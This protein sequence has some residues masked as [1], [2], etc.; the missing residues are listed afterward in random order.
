MDGADTGELRGFAHPLR[1]RLLSLLTGT[2]MSAA[3]AARELGESQ[4]N[5]SYHMRRLRAAGL[6]ELAEE[7][8]IRGG[9]ARRYRHDPE[10]GMRQPGYTQQGHVATAAA[11]GRELRRRSAGRKPGAGRSSLTDAEL[12]VEPEV[13]EE[14]VAGVAALSTRLHAAARPPHSPGTIRTSTTVS[15]FE[16]DEP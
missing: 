3:E 5:V 15:L 14:I 12:W 8:P 1:L 4:A 9:R 7:V 10:S 11:L 2:A 6:L 13:W 16:M